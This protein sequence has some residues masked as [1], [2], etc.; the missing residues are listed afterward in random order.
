MHGQEDGFRFLR[1]FTRRTSKP[2]CVKRTKAR[3]F[4]TSQVERL[5]FIA[6]WLVPNWV[7][8]SPKFQVLHLTGTRTDPLSRGSSRAPIDRERYIY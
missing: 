6:N 2:C 8:D 5:F 7:L 3:K 1:G 4:G